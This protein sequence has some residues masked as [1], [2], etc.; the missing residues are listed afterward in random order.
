MNYLK[1]VKDIN[2]VYKCWKFYMWDKLYKVLRSDFFLNISDKWY[3]VRIWAGEVWHAETTHKEH[4]GDSR[5]HQCPPSEDGEGIQ[6]ADCIN[7]S[8]LI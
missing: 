2:K 7:G 1:L 6:P 3:C 5:W 4:T 8:V